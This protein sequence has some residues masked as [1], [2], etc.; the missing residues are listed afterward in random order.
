MRKINTGIISTN[1]RTM[2]ANSSARMGT[3][4][5]INVSEVN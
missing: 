3:G 2:D 1:A 4:G 5:S